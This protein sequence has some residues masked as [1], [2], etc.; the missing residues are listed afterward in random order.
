MTHPVILIGAATIA[1]EEQVERHPPF[2]WITPWVN[3]HEVEII[4]AFRPLHLIAYL[5]GV[6]ASYCFLIVIDFHSRKGLITL[7]FW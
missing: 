5:L 2:L 4:V 6:S 3:Q 7:S 1:P